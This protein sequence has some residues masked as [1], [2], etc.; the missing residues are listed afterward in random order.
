MSFVTDGDVH[1]ATGVSCERGAFCK[2]YSGDRVVVAPWGNRRS[3]EGAV[4]QRKP[5]GWDSCTDFTKSVLFF[6]QSFLCSGV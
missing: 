2:M 5:A 1:V 6:L 3:H 4:V